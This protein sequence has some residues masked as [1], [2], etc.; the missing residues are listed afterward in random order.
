MTS[1]DARHGQV[2]GSAII[3]ALEAGGSVA[4]LLESAKPMPLGNV[5][6]IVTEVAEELSRAHEKGWVHGALTPENILFGGDG[7]ARLAD[8][9]ISETLRSAGLVSE[10]GGAHEHAF[11]APEQWRGQRVDSRTDQYS[12]AL[13]AYELLTGHR[14]L[15]AAEAGGV[16]MLDPVEVQAHTPLGR[17]IPLYVNEALRMALSANPAHRFATA[18]QFADAFCGRTPQEG[19]GLPTRRTELGSSARM[20]ITPVVIGLVVVGGL[21]VAFNPRAKTAAVSTWNGI[22]TRY[23]PPEVKVDASLS[24]DPGAG[25]RPS[26]GSSAPKPIAGTGLTSTSGAAPSGP[27][28]SASSSSM[29][30][31]M[32]SLNSGVEPAATGRPGREMDVRL[33][34]AN[35]NPGASPDRSPGDR[36]A[37]D[38]AKGSATSRASGVARSWASKL[39][40]AVTS[41]VSSPPPA[42]YLVV[43]VDRGTAVVT[44]D[45]IPRGTAPVVAR[46]G[47]GHHTVSVTGTS[48]YTPSSTGITATAGD[49][50]RASFRATS[51]R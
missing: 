20:R 25:T 40:R 13:I 38:L 42:A 37:T 6:R 4:K 11:A 35:V 36:S 31:T 27:A 39:K 48:D 21:V 29:S 12:L 45:G 19:E 24:I 5:Q 1:G 30:P 16:K 23:A 32:S 22:W 2:K 14:R 46:V 3:T 41:F 18:T 47:A 10:A 28:P 34:R 15:D 7:R 26:S 50:V 8:F 9:G 17:G 33:G 51:P 44:I 43:D 49:T